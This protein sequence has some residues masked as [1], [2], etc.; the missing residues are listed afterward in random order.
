MWIAPGRGVWGAGRLLPLAEMK[1]KVEEKGRRKV[2][3]LN[4]ADYLAGHRV[5]RRDLKEIRLVETV[6]GNH[7]VD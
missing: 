3:D 1:Q 6:P 7:W 4:G 5:C 2:L